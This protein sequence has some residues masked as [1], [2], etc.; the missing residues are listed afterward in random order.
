MTTAI[1]QR[2]AFGRTLVELADADDRVL[3]LDGD[4]ANSTKADIFAEAHPER[5]LAMGIAEQNMAGVA[6]G[7][8]TLGFVPWISTFA[9]FAVKRDLDQVRVVIAQ[10]SLNVKIAG[11]YS[12]STP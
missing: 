3:V 12:L 5:F 11:A 6:A 8:A 2:E 9:A 4:L 1:A 7:L 10:P